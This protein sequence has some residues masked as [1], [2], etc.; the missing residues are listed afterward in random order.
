[1]KRSLLALC[2][3]LPFAAFAAEDKD[4]W[5]QLFDGKSLKAGR[6]MRTRRLSL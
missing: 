4:E 1:M 5:V 6:S 3:A 2:L